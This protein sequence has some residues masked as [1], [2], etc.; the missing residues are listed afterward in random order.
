MRQ[1][2]SDWPDGHCSL[3]AFVLYARL[4]RVCKCEPIKEFDKF[5]AAYLEH[6]SD[7]RMQGALCVV[8]FNLDVAPA[9][10]IPVT[11]DAGAQ[12]RLLLQVDDI[13]GMRW[14]GGGKLRFTVDDYQER[15]RKTY[16]L[17]EPFEL[18]FPWSTG[19]WYHYHAFWRDAVVVF[20]NP[21]PP[22]FQIKSYVFH[23]EKSLYL[24]KQQHTHQFR[25]CL[26]QIK[27][28]NV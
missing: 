3:Q 26:N 19:W 21:L 1:W 14:T 20:T 6:Q 22:G 15:R 13:S 24:E 23:G 4:R 28:R 25:A 10:W 27:A 5:S 7:P 11:E 16:E 18:D 17:K 8:Q 12:T 2:I 9:Q